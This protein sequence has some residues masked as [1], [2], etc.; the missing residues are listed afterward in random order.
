MASTLRISSFHTSPSTTFNLYADVISTQA[1]PAG[2]G[3]GR[4]LVEMT[5]QAVNGPGGSSS[6]QFNNTGA[7]VG[8]VNGGEWVAHR[9]NPFLPSGTPNGSQR[10]SHTVSYWVNANS[11]GYW[12]GTTTTLPLTMGLSYGSVNVSP[13]GSIT[14]NRL[15]TSPGQPQAP[16]F[17]SSTDRSIDFTIYYPSS[18]GGSPIIDYT[19]QVGTNSSFSTI[20]KQWTGTSGSQSVSD[21]SPLTQYAVRYYARNAVGGSSWSPT[22]L[23]STQ[24]LT[25]PSIAVSPSVSGGSA[26]VLVSPGPSTVPDSYD[27]QYEYLSPPP[28][29]APATHTVNTTSTSLVV[30]GLVKGASYRW[31]ALSHSGT[32]TSPWSGWITVVQPSPSTSAGDYFDGS[33][34]ATDVQTFS[35]TGAVNNSTSVATGVGVVNWVVVTTAGGNPRLQRVTRGVSGSYAARALVFSDMTGAGLYLGMD[36]T[37]SHIASVE[38]NTMYV[39]S[40]HVRPS[41]A[42]RM[43]VEIVWKDAAGNE[44][45]RANGAAQ[46][47]TSDTWTRLTVQALAPVNAE[48]AVV[49]AKDVAGDGWVAWKG[50]EWLDA[51]AAMLT[52]G[53][54]YPYFDGSTPDTIQY[55]YDWGGT[56]F[57]SVSIR[58]TLPDVTSDLLVD[59]DCPPVPGPPSLPVIDSSCIEDIGIWR[60]YWVTIPASEVGVWRVTVP[61]VTLR[62]GSLPARQIRIRTYQNPFNYTTSGID[63]TSWCAEQIISYMPA[64]TVFTLDGVFERAWAEV[65]GRNAVAADHLLYGTDGEPA[66]WPALSCGVTH[67]MSLD[68]PLDAPESNLDIDVSLTYRE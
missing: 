31:R 32:F 41:R 21:L 67:L 3:Y 54:L 12:S 37:S 25:A 35:W 60:R 58:T 56:E 57:D 53:Q 22:T 46:V 28:I 24:A 63:Y 52:M 45:S 5:I 8:Y 14:L 26:T 39:G 15:A 38:Q 50:G 19:M 11:L 33:S 42:Q 4:W 2:A 59:P 1:A 65:Q 17:R 66:T 43:A 10:W 34:A 55:Q 68:V 40:I 44:V 64:S 48:T 29:P 20:V 62:T 47:V 49:R 61:T 6:S 18:D 30:S 36:F 7:Q 13:G 16:T 51:D 27:V 9:A 23:M